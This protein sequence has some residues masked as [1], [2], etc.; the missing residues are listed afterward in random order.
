MSTE[1]WSGEK[2]IVSEFHYKLHKHLLL[3][4]NNTQCSEFALAQFETEKLKA[5]SL[6]KTII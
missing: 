4:L 3:K 1:T 6:G 2:K 5:Y